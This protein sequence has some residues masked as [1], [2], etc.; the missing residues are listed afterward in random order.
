MKGLT[1]NPNTWAVAEP[2]QCRLIK[3]FESTFLNMEEQGKGDHH[4]QSVAVSKQ[5][6]AR[7][8][9]LCLQNSTS[10]EIHSR[11]PVLNSYIFILVV[12]P[13]RRQ[14]SDCDLL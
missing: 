9:V 1:E 4:S 10:V 5:I 13:N 12:V 8:Y 6:Q 7:C 11:K 2:E 3:E 14:L